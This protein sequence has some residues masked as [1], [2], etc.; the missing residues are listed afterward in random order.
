MFYDSLMCLS[1][2]RYTI[3]I[4][5]I[6]WATIVEKIKSSIEVSVF[7]EY[8]KFDDNSSLITTNMITFN[9]SGQSL[10]QR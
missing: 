8:R 10:F 6:T 3:D 4:K 5:M 2:C 1:P 9:D 7:N